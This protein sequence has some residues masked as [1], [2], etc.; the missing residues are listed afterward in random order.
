MVSAGRVQMV[1]LGRAW[2]TSFGLHEWSHRGCTNGLIRA[3]VDAPHEGWAFLAPM[4][5]IKVR[6]EAL[7]RG[8]GPNTSGCPTRRSYL[9]LGSQGE[10]MMHR[11]PE[12]RSQH[13]P[14]LSAAAKEA[15]MYEAR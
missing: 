4:L 8:C 15:S 14:L 10:A 1:A 2:M 5:S 13:R 9:W 6:Q 3:C 7:L 12:T 11:G